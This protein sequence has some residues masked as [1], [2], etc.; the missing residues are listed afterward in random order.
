VWRSVQPLRPTAQ[1][2]SR[3]A[4]QL[5][6]EQAQR[7]L[8]SGSFVPP[9]EIARLSSFFQFKVEIDPKSATLRHP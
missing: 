2:Q 3:Y 8:R 5:A 4:E 1:R 7:G 9:W 6:A